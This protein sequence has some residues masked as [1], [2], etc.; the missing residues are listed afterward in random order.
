MPRLRGSSP[1]YPVP[2]STTGGGGT[3]SLTGSCACSAASDHADCTTTPS[4]TATSDAASRPNPAHVSAA[5]VRVRNGP[6][7]T[8]SAASPSI[9][10]TPSSPMSHGIPRVCAGLPPH[11]EDQKPTYT[12]RSPASAPRASPSEKSSRTSTG[13]Q[14]S[15]GCRSS[16]RCATHDAP[17][18]VRTHSHHRSSAR[19]P[20]TAASA[21]RGGSDSTPAT[22]GTTTRSRPTVHPSARPTPSAAPAATPPAAAAGGSTSHTGGAR[23]KS[24]GTARPTSH[25][26][27]APPAPNAMLPA[28]SCAAARR[29]CAALTSAMRSG[30]GGDA[31]DVGSHRTCGPGRRR[32]AAGCRD[33]GAHDPRIRDVEP[34]LPAARPA[35][36]ATARADPRREVHGVDAGG[37]EHRDV[38]HVHASARHELDGSVQLARHALQHV[39]AGAAVDGPARGQHTA[40]RRCRRARPPPRAG[41]PRHP[42]LGAQ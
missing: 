23:K 30:A 37:R 35:G 11:Q 3:G 33:R 19:A 4:M 2:G 20:N 9:P 38:A 26:S 40:H 21:N 32:P 5:L 6:S 42:L 15:S 10:P 1:G 7:E 41:R 39:A 8:T 28:A 27:T 36:S 14:S 13:R 34:G 17:T 12:T 25:A 31:V 18:A 24:I 16:R 22:S 29:C